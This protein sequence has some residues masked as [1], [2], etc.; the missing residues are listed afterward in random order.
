[1][2]GRNQLRRYRI[3]TPSEAVSPAGVDDEAAQLLETEEV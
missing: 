3:P 1:M 2:D